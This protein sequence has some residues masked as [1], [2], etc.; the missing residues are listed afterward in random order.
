MSSL[1]DEY[2]LV[3]EPEGEDHIF[4]KPTEETAARGYSYKKMDVLSEPFH[5]L[6]SEADDD[7]SEGIRRPLTNVLMDATNLIV[8]DS[9]HAYL[10][11]WNIDGLQYHPAVY[12][13]ELGNT[14]KPYW[15]L[16]FFDKTL[17]LDT[18]RSQLLR[19]TSATYDKQSSLP[20]D[21]YCL[22]AEVLN[23]IPVT[24]RLLF[25]IGGTNM[26]YVFAHQTIVDKFHEA[27]WDGVRFFK[28]SEFEEGDQY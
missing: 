27:G 19:N 2:Y 14:H 9:I 20:V 5:F 8:D 3:M 23:Q 1:D 7:L 15:H 11:Q 12:T 18:E 25:K 4:L 6:N 22:D 17:C 28:V 21:S 13:D 16:T 10:S 26:G 24:Q